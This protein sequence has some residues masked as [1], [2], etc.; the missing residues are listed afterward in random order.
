MPVEPLV[1][2]DS[3]TGALR[4][5]GELQAAYAATPANQPRVMKSQALQSE[6]PQIAV[7]GAFGS[8]NLGNECTLYALLHNLRLLL[9]GASLCCVCTGPEK[10]AA[11]YGIPALPIRF[12]RLPQNPNRLLRVLAKIVSVVPLECWRWYHVF[13][14]LR[15]RHMLVMAGT[16][17]LSDVGIV[18]MGLHYDILRWS[19]VA[20]LCRCRVLFVSVGGG[21]IR[22]PLSRLFVRTSLRLA[23]FRSYRDAFSREYVSSIG[24]RSDRDEIMPDLAFSLPRAMTACA[25]PASRMTR[26]IGLGVITHSRRRATAQNDDTLYQEYIS[27][28][29]AFAAQILRKDYTI[30]LLVGDIVYDGRAKAD[31]LTTLEREGVTW[32]PSQLLD[33]PVSSFQDLLAQMASTDV[34]IASRFHNVLLSVALNKPVVAISFHE[35]VD[36]L[37]KA[38][39]LEAYC[40]DIENIDVNGLVAKLAAAEENAEVLK[41]QMRRA[42]ETWRQALAHQYRTIVD[43]AEEGSPVF[44]G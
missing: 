27:K 22:R 19:L 6:G 42:T 34:V 8:G 3:R 9:P 16:G 20:R 33:E 43:M 41:Q 40:Q 5:S 2:L 24:F 23:K 4:D 11:Q 35:K 7:F 18:P 38:A 17:M 28:L 31:L 12:G 10:A 30:R 32:A 13:R 21:P 15:G 25:V 37:M 36:A 26:I 14:S 39:G 44:C 29:A 1:V